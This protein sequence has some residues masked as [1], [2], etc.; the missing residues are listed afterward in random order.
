MKSGPFNNQT[1]NPWRKLS[2]EDFLPLNIDQC[3]IFTVNSMKMR[4]IVIPV[5]HP[6][7]MPKKKLI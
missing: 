1:K 3:F 7:M 4:W 2:A 6:K 5:K